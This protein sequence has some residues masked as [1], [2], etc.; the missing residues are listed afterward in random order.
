MLSRPAHAATAGLADERSCVLLVPSI[1]VP[2]EY[3]VLINPA[4]TEIRG[5]RCI[6]STSVELGQA[7]QPP[8]DEIG[9]VGEVDVLSV[10][11]ANEAGWSSELQSESPTIDALGVTQAGL[12]P[13]SQIAAA[14]HVDTSAMPR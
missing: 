14:S 13:A 2:I 3:N 9:V 7:A 8:G 4:H 11:V 12:L 1:I 6:L 5:S 10:T